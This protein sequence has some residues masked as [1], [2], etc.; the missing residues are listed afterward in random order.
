M[1][2]EGTWNGGGRDRGKQRTLCHEGMVVVRASRV[3]P[4]R[5]SKKP[6]SNAKLPLMMTRLQW[7]VS[8][9]EHPPTFTRD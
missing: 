1:V 7:T 4:E 6:A 8:A 3:R 2:E 9:G 5:A